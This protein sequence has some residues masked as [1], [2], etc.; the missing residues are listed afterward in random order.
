MTSFVQGRHRY[1]VA[2]LPDRGPDGRGRADTW[3]WPSSVV[4]VSP[5]EA[6]AADVDVVVLQR[7]VELELVPSWLGGRRPRRDVPA[8]YVE[9]NT[10]QGRIADM[11]HPLAD[12]CDLSLVHVTH[13][14]ALFWDSGRAP[15]HIVEHGVLDPGHRFTGTLPRAV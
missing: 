10:P 15:L 9:H 13:F 5:A 1:L 7:P 3:D 14:N 8:G 12:R 6:A 2:T 4:E 11:R